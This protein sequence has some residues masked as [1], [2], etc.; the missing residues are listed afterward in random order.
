MRAHAR[1]V[2]ARLVG[3]AQ[4]YARRSI[5]FDVSG[6][7][8]SPEAVA[9][10]VA[11][12]RERGVEVVDSVDSEDA[13]RRVALASRDFYWYS[14]KL[15]R[16]LRGMKGD[17]LVVAR[18]EEDVVNAAG[19]AARRGVPLT[20]R[21]AGTGNYGQAVPMRG[22]LVLDLSPMDQI[23][24]FDARDGIVR[25]HAGINLATLEETTR[26][27]GWELRQHPSTRRTATLGGF[28]AGGS[29]GVGAVT[30]GGLAE[31]G[32][33]LGLRVVTAEPSPRILELRGRDVFPVV[34]AYGTNG[35]VTEV[36]VPLA[37]AQPWWD[38]VYRFPTL[39]HAAKF[40]LELGEAP[41]IVA[42]EVSVHQSPTFARELAHTA[43]GGMLRDAGAGDAHVVLA[44]MAKPSLGP[45]LRLARDNDG[46]ACFEPSRSED[47]ALGIPLYEYAWNH[48]T[49][50]ALKRDKSVT[51]LQAAMMP[52]EAL[53]LVTAVEQRYGADELVQ[54]L[55]V[56]RFGGRIGFASLAL[57][58]PGTDAAVAVDKVEEV[59]RWHEANGVPV[60]NPHTHVLEDGGM[61][62][63]DWAQLGFKSGADPNGVLNPGKM[64]AWE[65]GKATTEASDPRG[66]FSAAY[67]LAQSDGASVANKDPNKKP[68]PNSKEDIMAN[69]ANRANEE[70][71]APPP[72]TTRERKMSRLWSE[73][74]TEDFATADLSDAVA[75]LPLGATE[76]H[77]PHLPLGVDSMHNAALLARA[78]ELVR[79][80]VRVLALPPLDIGVSCEHGG[81]A[82]TVGIAPETAAKQWEE[83]GA[84][85]ARAGIR[86]LILYNSHGG[87]HALAEVVARRLR[88]RHRMIAAL[89]LNLAMDDDGCAGALFPTDELRFGIHGGS[90]ETSVMMHLR[91]ELVDA[92][93]AAH[94][95]SS[96]AQMGGKTLQRH[97]LGF[98]VKTGWASQD[99]NPHGVVGDASDATD[100]K[101]AKLVESSAR[102]LARLIEEMHATCADE[103]TGTAPLYPPQGTDEEI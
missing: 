13:A 71:N 37:R 59:M 32:A 62:Q 28:V 96:A 101:G 72:T 73:W 83:I 76:A 89:A 10:A 74:T 46:D 48:T 52:G 11:E 53:D 60:F 45:A 50:H 29:T 15:K 24:S 23:V 6:A 8:V 12:L 93:K 90:L 103:W 58:R 79:H 51:Y 17:A 92:S 82:G 19:V 95:A 57:L 56:V 2:V 21:G 75:V 81:F 5:A 27:E 49:L 94:F 1:T 22:G 85:V 9:G 43:L 63:T 66:S 84:C 25:A 47:L 18:S 69:R 14:P 40:A 67:R 61:K 26:A 42:R 100:S 38:G 4:E 70:S 55:E 98:G 30:H 99:L 41:A 36:E 86:K 33:V 80:D 91:P 64:R 88:L 77:G 34:H 16:E 39:R 20:P 3:G 65:E 35:V 31:D 68:N 44:Q 7:R 102:G 54:H 78:L 97:A 87:N